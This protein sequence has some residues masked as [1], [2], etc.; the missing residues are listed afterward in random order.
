MFGSAKSKAGMVN[1]ENNECQYNRNLDMSVHT[2]YQRYIIFLCP[3][4]Y[5]L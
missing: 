5:M 2:V 3:S 4:I 1:R